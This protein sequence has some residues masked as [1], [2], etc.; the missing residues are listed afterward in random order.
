MLIYFTKTDGHTVAINSDKV[1]SVAAI[2][3]AGMPC[4]AIWSEKVQWKVKDPFK[5]VVARLNNL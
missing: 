5:E 4:T 3:E 2:F 1:L